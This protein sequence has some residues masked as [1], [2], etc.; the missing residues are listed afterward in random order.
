MEPKLWC[1]LGDLTKD[2]C[3]YETAWRVSKGR[4]AR[5]K[6]SLARGAAIKQDWEAAAK[7]W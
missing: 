2:E 4:H 3:H 1:A 6:R 5:A 7:H